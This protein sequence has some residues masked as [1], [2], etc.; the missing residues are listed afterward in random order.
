MATTA[1]NASMLQLIRELQN[2]DVQIEFQL[3]PEKYLDQSG[4]SLSSSQVSALQ[5]LSSE[6]LRTLEN[7]AERMELNTG[8]ILDHEGGLIY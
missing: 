7:I 6:E 4:L 3:N 8:E 1:T 5:Q 2:S